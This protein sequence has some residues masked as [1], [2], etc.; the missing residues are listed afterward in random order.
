MRF[1]VPRRRSS[2]LAAVPAAGA[3]LALASS[4]SAAEGHLLY[5]PQEPAAVLHD[6]LGGGTLRQAPLRPNPRWPAS[7]VV[8]KVTG[9]ELAGSGARRIEARLRAGWRRPGVGGLV[10]VDEITP[11]Q[12]SPTASRALRA[13]LTRMGDD[14]ERVVFYASPALV[15]Q[16][17]RADPRRRLPGRLRHLV[18]AISRGGATFLQTYRGDSSPFPAREMATH[19]TRWLERWPARGGDLR[20]MLGPDRGAGQAELWS[21]VRS[22]PAGRELLSRGPA[23]YGL[24]TAAE[25]REWLDQYR[26]FRAT[27]T[28]SVTGSDFPVPEPGGLSLTALSSSRVRIAITRP[29]RAV[30]TMTPVRGGFRRA[31]RKLTGPR[32]TVIR[33]PR[34]SRPGRYRVRAVLIGDGLRDRDAVIVR[35]PRRP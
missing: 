35:V 8:G 17:G 30:V 21:R 23:A 25:A 26:A 28:V 20:I 2:L 11:R 3:L 10:G 27:P 14:A 19:P 24:D 13:A 22:T 6:G 9:R 33:L 18:A 16:V 15:E 4:A 31:I 7:K 12:W 32:K 5:L 1:A 34:D 29:G